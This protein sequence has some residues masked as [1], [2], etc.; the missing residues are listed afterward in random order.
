M[1]PS[2]AV[3]ARIAL[4][5]LCTAC[6]SSGSPR[7]PSAGPRPDGEVISRAQLEERNFS[8]ALE[9]V[10]SLRSNWLRTRGIDS[11]NSR[12]PIWVYLGNNRLGGLE[13][14]RYITPRSVAFLRRY[15]G[16]QATARWGMGHGQG[17]IY[18]ESY[19]GFERR[20]VAG[21]VQENPP[22][23]SPPDS[24]PAPAAKPVQ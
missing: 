8:T 22:P 9:L 5:V 14:L 2:A 10:Q 6:A 23:A 19:S 17:A 21:T 16:V 20:E 12:T 7:S 11:F 1:H 13:T 24:T 18:M 15:D 3:L 4:A